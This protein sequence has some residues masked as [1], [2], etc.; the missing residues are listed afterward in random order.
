[1]P[2]VRRFAPAPI[3]VPFPPKQLPKATAQARGWI[4]NC[5]L[6]DRIRMIGIMIE[7][8]ATLSMKQERRPVNHKINRSVEERD[9]E[10]D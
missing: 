6:L 9:E 2:A 4:G 1:M 8:I 7:I 5:N 10:I 3:K